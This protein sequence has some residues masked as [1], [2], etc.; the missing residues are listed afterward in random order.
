MMLADS[1]TLP[2]SFSRY[3]PFFHT[4]GRVSIMADR[5]FASI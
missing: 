3:L 5:W 4:S 1:V 2:A